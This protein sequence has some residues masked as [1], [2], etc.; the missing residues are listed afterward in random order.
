ML[1]KENGKMIL[2]V[3]DEALIALDEENILKK[4]GYRVITE[5]SGEDAVERVNTDTDIDLVLMDIGLG[6]GIDGTEAAGRILEKRD[7]AVVFL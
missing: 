7:V 3:E 1:M 2:L 5:Y 4:H 6:M